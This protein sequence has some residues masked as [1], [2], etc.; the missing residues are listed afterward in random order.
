MRVADRVAREWRGL[1]EGEDLSYGNGIA[2]KNHTQNTFVTIEG[3]R[4]IAIFIPRHRRKISTSDPA[5]EIQKSN[6]AVLEMMGYFIID[7]PDDFDQLGRMSPGA[8][9]VLG[10]SW[11]SELAPDAETIREFEANIRICLNEVVT[12]HEER[13]DK[14][15]GDTLADSRREA[16]ILASAIHRDIRLFPEQREHLYRELLWAVLDSGAGDSA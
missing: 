16:R 3:D 2:I 8:R 6:A 15:F 4:I 13:I 10:D 11:L 7:D 1:S 12:P 5:N 9:K 14:V